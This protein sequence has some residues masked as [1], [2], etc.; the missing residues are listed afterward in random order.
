MEVRGGGSAG[1]GDG[2]GDR[3][4]LRGEA[5][6]PA[7]DERAQLVATGAG[8]DAVEALVAQGLEALQGAG[9]AELVDG[10]Q[11]VI[12]RVL[13]DWLAEQ[14]GAAVDVAQVVGDRVVVAQVGDSRVYLARH[15]EVTQLT[16]DHTWLNFQAQHGLLTSDRARPGAGKNII[17]RAVGLHDHVEVDILV[18]P[19]Q[20]GDRLLLCSDGLHTY[21]GAGTI[22]LDLFK[23]DVRAAARAAIHHANACGGADNITALFVEFLAI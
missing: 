19:V 22:L 3:S 18:V 13:A 12:D 1:G 2:G 10:G 14:L 15:G 16:E 21:L 6:G 20:P 17:T 11:A 9:H 4:G 8:G 23:L 5:G 7:A